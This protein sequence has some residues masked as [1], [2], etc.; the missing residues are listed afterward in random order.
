MKNWLERRVLT[1]QFGTFDED[2]YSIPYMTVL[3][4]HNLPGLYDHKE[5][6]VRYFKP[7]PRYIVPPLRG[8]GPR[9]HR[10]AALLLRGGISTPLPT[11][12][13]PSRGDGSLL[14]QARTR[15]DAQVS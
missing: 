14:E 13:V 5:G 7:Y 9:T 3:L 4:R 12:A 2:S 11:S 10:R 1:I 8:E 6:G 15:D